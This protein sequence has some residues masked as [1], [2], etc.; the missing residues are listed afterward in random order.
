MD[1]LFERGR[2]LKVPASR[3]APISN[4]EGWRSWSF[5]VSSF[6][7]EST[8]LEGFVVWFV[9]MSNRSIAAAMWGASPERRATGERRIGS[10]GEGEQGPR[11]C[12]MTPGGT[13]R[14]P[15]EVRLNDRLAQASMEM[16]EFFK[17]TKSTK[18]QENMVAEFFQ[19]CESECP[20][21]MHRHTLD[22]EKVNRWMMCQAPREVK[23]RGGTTDGRA[24]NK[25][26]MHFDE[27]DC[28]SVI[29]SIDN[30]PVCELTGKKIHP[31]PAKPCGAANFNGWKSLLKKIHRVQLSRKAQSRTWEMIWLCGLDELHKHVEERSPIMAKLNYEEKVNGEFAPCAVVEKYDE[32]ELTCWQD[33]HQ[34]NRRS[35]V[36]QLRHRYCLLHLTSGI[37]RAESLHRADISDFQS[38]TVPKLSTD[39]HNIYVMVNQIPHGKTTH[40]RM[41]YGRATRHKEVA[42]CCVGA[43]AFYLTM[44]FYLTGEFAS[45]TAEDWSDKSTWFDIKLLAD[46]GGADR[47]KE[48]RND[49]CAKHIKNVL[50]RLSVLCSK[51]LHLGRQLGAKILDLLQEEESNIDAMGQWAQS[52][53]QRCYSTKLPMGPIRR[54][55]GYEDGKTYFN[56]RTQVIP[57]DELRKLTPMGAWC[58]ESHS[59]LMLCSEPG[60]NKTALA[61]LKFFCELN[62][63]FLQDAAAMMYYH[64]ERASHPMFSELSVFRT[65]EF[66]VSMA[67]LNVSAVT[68][69]T[70]FLDYLA[71]PR[72]DEVGAM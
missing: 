49:Q 21:D 60:T 11:A 63:V 5:E 29:G 16:G 52:I 57:S 27:G 18:Q 36:S 41:Q 45:M 50:Q 39:V 14:H 54:L 55:A 70:N 59:N 25:L 8:T 47:T 40:G 65:E 22:S 56:T 20:H 13:F 44:R 28:D 31:L 33:S 10:P 15:D 72:A 6:S 12:V 38:L 43:L 53:R 66:K 69:L 9:K 62:D 34:T 42:L 51:L 4:I 35:M 19:F 1:P 48:M 32:I 26:G 24:R 37:L 46:V 71:F 58:Y 17:E 61:V 23:P 3:L 7:M 64:P 68:P 2:P 30:A 67:L